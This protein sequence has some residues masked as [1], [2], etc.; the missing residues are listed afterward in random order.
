MYGNCWE[1]FT[2]SSHPTGGLSLQIF[3]KLNCNI[4]KDNLEDHHLLNDDRVIIKV[5]KR[6]D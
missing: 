6:R 4:V 3:D 5:S 1:N 2:S